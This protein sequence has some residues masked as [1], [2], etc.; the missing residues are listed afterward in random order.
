MLHPY[1]RS[2]AFQAINP[3][4]NQPVAPPLTAQAVNLSV[5]QPIDPPLTAQ[6]VNSSAN[7]PVDPPLTAQAVNLS[8]DQPID[9]PIDLAESGSPHDSQT[10]RLRYPIAPWIG[11]LISPDP[12]PADDSVEFEVYHAPSPHQRLIRQVVSLQWASDQTTQTYVQSVIRDIRFSAIAHSSMA[13][14]RIHPTRLNGLNQ[15]GPLE[16]LAGA[17]PND[18]IEVML[19]EPVVMSEPGGQTTLIIAQEPIQVT[20]TFY[21]VVTIRERLS[22][23]DG[24]DRDPNSTQTNQCFR[25]QHY[26]PVTQQ[27]DGLNGSDADSGWSPE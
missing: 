27:F 23:A 24:N 16:S 2:L 22:D 14:G 4:A 15:V 20:G 5:D 11:R 13:K 8:V 6:A 18:D 26:N 25:V 9:P 21:S 12:R 3:S 19:H 1:A 7:Q 10:H 17:R